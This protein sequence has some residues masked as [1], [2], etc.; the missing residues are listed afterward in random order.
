[1]NDITRLT[2][3]ETQALE[4]LYYKG[5]FSFQHQGETWN[6]EG[7]KKI[8]QKKNWRN[9]LVVYK[10]EERVFLDLQ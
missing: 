2:L 6:I 10:G 7:V 1:M 8:K 4:S 5:V 9:V 3:S